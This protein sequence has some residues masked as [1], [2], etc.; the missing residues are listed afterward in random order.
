MAATITAGTGRTVIVPVEPAVNMALD[1][2]VKMTK[3]GWL[4]PTHFFPISSGRSWAF[5][6]LGL[7]KQSSCRPEQ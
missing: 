4:N 1:G 6:I 3:Q 7:H 5:V 2:G